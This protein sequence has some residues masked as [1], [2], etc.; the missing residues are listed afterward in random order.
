[1]EAGLVLA[2]YLIFC[3]WIYILLLEAALNGNAN[4]PPQVHKGILIVTSIYNTVMNTQRSQV[5]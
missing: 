2:N 3:M 4:D 5:S 1:M